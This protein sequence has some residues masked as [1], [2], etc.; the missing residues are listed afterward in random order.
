MEVFE[1]DYECQR[2]EKRQKLSKNAKIRV[3]KSLQ[4]TPIHLGSIK[5]LFSNL[6]GDSFALEAEKP[7]KHKKF[8]KNLKKSRFKKIA[9]I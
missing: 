8:S 1:N 6:K 5:N 7:K 2:I 9:K 4:D 3:V